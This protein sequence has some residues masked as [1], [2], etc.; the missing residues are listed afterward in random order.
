MESCINEDYEGKGGI[1]NNLQ[2]NEMI[3]QMSSNIC[4]I[5]DINGEKATGFFSKIPFPDDFTL[6]PVLIS[7]SK[8]LNKENTQINKTI[9][10]TL[11]DDK[12]SEFYLLIDSSRRIL[13]DDSLGVSVIEIKDK[14]KI[15]K[16]LDIDDNINK[17]DYINLYKRKPEV[18]TLNYSEKEN[19]FYSSYSGGMIKEIFDNIIRYSCKA[20]LY[21]PGAPILLISNYKVIGIHTRTIKRQN[22]KEYSEGIFIKCV[23]EK[24]KNKFLMKQKNKKNIIIKNKHYDSENQ[25]GNNNSNYFQDRKEN[26]FIEIFI[27]NENEN[28]DI[29]I[30]NK[31]DSKIYCT[32]IN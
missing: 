15:N 32:V 24:F 12:K 5:H 7:N 4:L 1:I 16:F 18:Y 13:I 2:I 21:S 28:E 22:D 11:D 25:I 31:I 8:I 27:E 9:Y 30:I 20:C 6:L 23:I 17:E 26:G 29:T 19:I 3:R 10:L 14:D